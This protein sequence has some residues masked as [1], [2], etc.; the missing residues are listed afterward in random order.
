MNRFPTNVWDVTFEKVWSQIK[1]DLGHIKI[2][3]C[4][5]MVHAPKEIRKNWDVKSQCL[6]F[7]GYSETS[8]GYRFIHSKR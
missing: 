1:P 2:F 3:V 5:A 8:K 7:T 4:N 6:I